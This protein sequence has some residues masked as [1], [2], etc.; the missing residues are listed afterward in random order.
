MSRVIYLVASTLEQGI[1]DAEARG[2]VRIART[3]FAGAE[4]EKDDIRVINRLIDLVPMAAK[5][6]MIQG[7]DYQEPPASE[8]ELALNRWLEEHEAFEK[9]VADGHGE[10][11]A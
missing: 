6:P 3:R 7:S 4:P 9:F 2:A 1:K 11:V 5:T 8:S 10:W